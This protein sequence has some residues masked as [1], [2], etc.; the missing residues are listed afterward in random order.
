MKKEDQI[1]FLLPTV[2]IYNL[3]QEINLNAGDLI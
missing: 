3:V 1:A 2:C